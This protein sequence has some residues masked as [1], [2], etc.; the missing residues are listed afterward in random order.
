MGH[1]SVSHLACN[2]S[3]H[4]WCRVN[5]RPSKW[6]EQGVKTLAPDASD[7]DVIEHSSRRPESFGLIFDRHAISVHRFI[8]RRTDTETADDVL[9]EVFAAAFKRRD[10]FDLTYDSAL[11]WL[12]GI[13]L[14]SIRRSWRTTLAQQRASS[15]AALETAVPSHE[16]DAADRLDAVE[17]W[18]RLRPLVDELADG[19]RQAL[20]LYAWEDLTYAQIAL[21]LNVP[22]GTVRSRIHRARAHLQKR[23]EEVIPK[24]THHDR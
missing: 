24:E 20:L 10:R 16:D 4:D 23:L 22:V 7:A 8:A 17:R 9:S 19:D 5:R 6:L 14:N 12:Y 15:R 1:G 11:P 2:D 21:A 18:A 3:S 13:A